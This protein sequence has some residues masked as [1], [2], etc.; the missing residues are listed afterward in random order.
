MMK[1]WVQ[2]IIEVFFMEKVWVCVIKLSVVCVLV[3]I[4]FLKRERLDKDW[5]MEGRVKVGMN[6][7][8]ERNDV[9]SLLI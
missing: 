3:F 8:I 1:I 2:V 4:Y 7:E 9:Y 6:L 5:Q